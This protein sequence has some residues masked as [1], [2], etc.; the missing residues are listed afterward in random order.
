MNR[1]E[2]ISTD[3]NKPLLF[4]KVEKPKLKPGEVLIKNKAFSI[5]PVDVKTRFG[6]GIYG[7]LKNE[8]HI[9]LGWDVAGEVMELGEGVEYLS[10]GDKVFGMINF[11]GHGKA[12]SEYVAAPEEHITII[13]AG[14]SYAEAA[15][16]TLAALTAYQILNRHI[17]ENDRVFIQSAAGGVGHFAVQIAKLL[18]AHVIGTASEKNK[19][20]LMDLGIDEFIDYKKRAFEDSTKN[21]DFALDTMGGEVLL[22]TF[23]IMKEGGKIISIPTG[24]SP[25]TKNKAL[26]KDLHVDFELVQSSGE[27]MYQLAS[28]LKS[29]KIKPY[30]Y[31]EFK[32]NE[33]ELAHKQILSRSTRGKLIVS[34]DK[35]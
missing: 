26:A 10:L 21:I 9:I 28:W 20:F 6:G 19:E 22:K 3:N 14:I 31:E 1:I 34:W 18:G 30:I 11:P 2:L 27:D 23:G 5:N 15:A 12:Y 17:K 8:D 24:I 7:A 25:E 29:G 33:I 32:S 16:T 35:D 4:T 13:P